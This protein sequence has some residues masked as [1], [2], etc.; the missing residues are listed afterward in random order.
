MRDRLTLLIR[1]RLSKTCTDCADS[2]HVQHSPP[3]QFH[4]PS[5]LLEHTAATLFPGF[6]PKTP[7]YSNG[8]I[9]VAKPESQMGVSF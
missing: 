2:G 5:G 1:D 3:N 6:R 7:L 4:A 8:E 9:L